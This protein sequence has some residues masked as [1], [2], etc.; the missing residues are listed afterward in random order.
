MRRQRALL[1]RAVPALLLL[2]ADNTSAVA[3]R[4]IDTDSWIASGAQAVVA[5]E[6]VVGSRNG[7]GQV[8]VG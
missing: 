6:S 4:A 7:N 8:S 3:A 1:H 5:R 2:A